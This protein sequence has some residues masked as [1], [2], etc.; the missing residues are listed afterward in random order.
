MKKVN[1][2]TEAKLP[3]HFTNAVF[4]EDTGQMLDYNKLINH[5]NKET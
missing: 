1:A 2:R 4:N 3:A 5:N